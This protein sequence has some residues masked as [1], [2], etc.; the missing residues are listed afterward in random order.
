MS[1]PTHDAT[2]STVEA[3]PERNTKTTLIQIGVML[4]TVVV[5]TIA[6]LGFRTWWKPADPEPQ[7]VHITVATADTKEEIAPYSVCEQ[8]VECQEQPLTELSFGDDV[9]LTLPEAIYDHDWALL[10]IYDNPAKNDQS[11]Y[12]SHEK[13]EITLPTHEDDAQLMV[14]E[15]SSLMIGHDDQGEETPY[16]VTWSISSD[17]A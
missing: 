1:E 12:G 16:V 2:T 9:T 6:F 7:D 11:Y 10:K 14:I 8:G 17:K 3:A 5:V 15:V 13:Q 4:A